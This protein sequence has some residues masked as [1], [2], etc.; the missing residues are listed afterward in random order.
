MPIWKL[1]PI[2]ISSQNW[3]ASTYN[4]TVIVRAGTEQDA[5]RLASTT[6]GCGAPVIAGQPIAA[7]PWDNSTLVSCSLLK[8]S[9]YPERGADKILEPQSAA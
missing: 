9:S 5:R 4:G 7:V 8:Q 1:E 2:D 6:F 3:A